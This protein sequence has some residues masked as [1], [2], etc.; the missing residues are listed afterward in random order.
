MK[1]KIA[2]IGIVGVPAKYGG[3]ETM[4][5]NLI[6]HIDYNK[7]DVTIFCSKKSYPKNERI[8]FYKKCKLIYIPLRANGM[9][10]FLY[11]NL[12]LI[13][14]AFLKVDNVLALGTA[15]SLFYSIFKPFLKFKY[16]VNLDG[17]D[18]QREKFSYLIRFFLRL[19]RKLA[20]KNSSFII[21]D[22][23]G[24][25]DELSD[26][27]LLKT[28][29][30]EYGGDNP[31]YSLDKDFLK[32]LKLNEKS[33]FVSVARIEPENNASLILDSFSK[34]KEKLVYVGNWSNSQF[35]QK[36][37]N[38][39]RKY[40]NLILLD[41]IYDLRRLNILRIKSKGYI[42][43]H[44]RGGTNPSLVE[45]M[46]LKLPVVA[47]DVKFNRY[48]LD[49]KGLYFKD[50]DELNK[51]INSYSSYDLEKMSGEIHSVAKARYTWEIISN[52]YF[53]IF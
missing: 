4:V 31:Y 15:S 40:N 44:S 1:K 49:N 51:I 47:F 20:K 10:G 28:K 37:K 46:T 8:N 25:K 19:I 6:D 36:L 39:Y 29:L 26:K 52:K 7:Y 32:S 3:Y 34:S 42:H 24:I 9:Q 45:A 33:Y 13:C 27:Y 30:I 35:G 41:E 38:Y 11:D 17:E 22:N 48:T 16:I 53:K 50:V 2:I 21:V 43:G 18:H 23:Q 14:S 5:D 12:T